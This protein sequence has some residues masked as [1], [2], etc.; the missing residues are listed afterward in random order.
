MEGCDEVTM[1]EEAGKNKKRRDAKIEWR[2]RMGRE[3]M[4]RKGDMER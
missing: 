1:G 3:T 4:K 2:E